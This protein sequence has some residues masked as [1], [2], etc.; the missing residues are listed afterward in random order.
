VRCQVFYTDEFAISF[1]LG[2]L[3]AGGLNGLVRLDLNG[4]T[5]KK[6]LCKLKKRQKQRITVEHITT[7]QLILSLFN[8]N[9]FLL[10]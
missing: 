7:L 9:H 5:T 3:R 10:L 1:E 6:T 4:V 2:F 8:L